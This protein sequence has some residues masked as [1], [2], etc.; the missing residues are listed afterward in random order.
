MGGERD[1]ASLGSDANQRRIAKTVVRLV[2]SK[3]RGRALSMRVDQTGLRPGGGGDGGGGDDAWWQRTPVRRTPG[4]EARQQGS[5]S[6]G[7]FS[8]MAIVEAGA[9]GE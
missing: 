5:S 8:M 4:P 7:E 2:F 3:R 6:W 1:V 9:A